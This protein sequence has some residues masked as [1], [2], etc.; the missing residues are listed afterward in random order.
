MKLNYYAE[1]DSLY[2]DFKNKTSVDSKEVSD[3]LVLD[4]DESGKIIGLDI[5]NASKI[6]DLDKVETLS[7]PLV[8]NKIG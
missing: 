8:K 3:G 4:F 1:T 6:I 5:S 7:L 2:I